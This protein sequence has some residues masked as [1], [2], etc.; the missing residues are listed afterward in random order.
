[1]SEENSPRGSQI[2]EIELVTDELNAKS[3]IG[4]KKSLWSQAHH[5]PDISPSSKTNN[6]VS[7]D[8]LIIQWYYEMLYEGFK[9]MCYG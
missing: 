7:I 5:S 3:E 9:I 8:S 6:L 2:N 1:M 4:K